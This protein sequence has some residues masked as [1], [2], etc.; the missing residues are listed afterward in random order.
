MIGLSHAERMVLLDIADP[1]AAV[2][3][4]GGISWDEHFARLPILDR[5]TEQRRAAP[6]ANGRG[7]QITDLGRLALRVAFVAENHQ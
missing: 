2:E 1:V 7:W 6:R 5:L 4:R 3:L